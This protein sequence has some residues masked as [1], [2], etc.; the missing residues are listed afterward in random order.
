MLSEVKKNLLTLS[1]LKAE[2]LNTSAFIV[3]NETGVIV[4]DTGIGKTIIS[5]TAIAEIGGKWIVAAPPAVCAGWWDEKIKWEHT[6]HLKV[7]HLNGSPEK[8]LQLMWQKYDVLMISLNSLDWL[9]EQNHG[10]TNII[11]DELSK[12]AGK[13]T[14]KLKTKRCDMITRRYG[15]TATPVSESFEKLYSMIRI[16]DKGVALGRNKQNYLL[17]YF[18]ATD[19]KQYNWE[20][21]AGSDRLILDNIKHLICDVKIDKNSGLPGIEFEE[22][23]FSMPQDTRA[24]YNTMKRDML[25]SGHNGIVAVNSAVLSGK[26]RQISSG[27]AISED[28]EVVEYDTAR[29]ETLLKI[30]PET[31]LI[32]YEYDHQRAQIEKIFN[33][34][35]VNFLSVFG[36]SDKDTAVF[37][38][39]TGCIDYLVA[40][41]LTLSHGVDGLQHATADVIFFA[42]LWS[43]DVTIQ[44]I[45]RV[46][47]NGQK[48]PVTITTIVCED[49]LD[50]LI[51]DRVEDKKTSMKNFLQHL[52][53]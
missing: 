43:N 50:D 53:G 38:F 12:C 26:L 24:I 23:E 21:N 19:Y 44:T 6:E 22:V 29:A 11:L 30:L 51:L 52:R 36:G 2:Q 3:N 27:F 14:A 46:H 41:A 15:L 16:L 10:C 33:A 37:A 34:N 5:L 45:G 18:H 20:I 40:Q 1:D 17:K 42:P 47:R 13:Q 49:T 25:I 31:A 32:I 4:G 28:D 48:K 8:R 9:L 39:T 35:D 7:V